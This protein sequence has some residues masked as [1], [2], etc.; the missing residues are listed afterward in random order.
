MTAI[1]PAECGPVPPAPRAP[2]RR[3][4]ARTTAR[5]R[6]APPDAAARCGS[7][8]ALADPTELTGPVFG[9][10]DVDGGRRRPH[11]RARR[12]GGRPAHHRHRPAAR[13]RRAPDPVVARRDLA[14]QRVRPLPPPRRP[15]AGPLDPNFTGGGR[16]LTDDDGTYRF[17]TIKPGR[18]PV[19]QPPQRLAP[20]AHPLLGVRAGVHASASSPR[21][22]SPTI[23]CSSR[24]RSSTPSPTRRPADG[25]S[26]LRPRRHEPPE[27]ALGF[28][29]DIVVR[30]PPATPFE[31]PA[32]MADRPMAPTPSQTVGPFLHLALA[33]P[34]ARHAVAAG[35]AGRHRRSAA[36]SSTATARRCPTPSS[37]RGSSTGRSPAARPDPTASGRCAR[38]QAARRRRRSTAR[39][40][41]RTSR[42]RC[43]PAGL[44][45]RV[46][47]RVLLRRRGRRQRRRSHAAPSVE[48]S[49]RTLARRRRHGERR[50]PLRHPP[51]G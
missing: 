37:R 26:P 15:V 10:G 45:D 4:T 51:A 14:G 48:P 21:C 49:R 27:W 35:H 5:R 17:T 38:R 25:S 47:T 44:L 23:R 20:G 16:A 24:T 1:S 19:G 9:D 6:R 50:L 36:G 39:R 8:P 43:S 30:G 22:T 40:R 7:H 34:A 46:V 2:T 18:L 32:P 29:F 3:S 12:R 42:S 31:E 11:G 13:R 28:R 41:R 33:D